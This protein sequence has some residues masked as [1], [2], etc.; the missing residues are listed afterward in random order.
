MVTVW[1]TAFS[2]GVF[3]RTGRALTA[4]LFSATAITYFLLG[5]PTGYPRRSNRAAD[6]AAGWGSLF[7]GLFLTAQIGHV[8]AGYATYGLVWGLAWRWC[9]HR[10]SDTSLAPW[11]DPGSGPRDHHVLRRHRHIVRRARGGVADRDPR[12]RQ[13]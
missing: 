1:G 4:F 3:H 10:C 8:L 9:T 11:T 13:T 5:W 12:V 7:L 6:S 2:F